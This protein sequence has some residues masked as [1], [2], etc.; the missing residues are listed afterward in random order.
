M[1][2]HTIK[3][4][5]ILFSTLIFAWVFPWLI[6][7]STND[8]SRYP[9]TYFSSVNKEFIQ[10]VKSTNNETLLKDLK[11]NEYTRDE[12]DSLLPMLSYRQL[13][14]DSRLPASLNG[15]ALNGKVI[16]ENQFY[17]RYSPRDKN[18]RVI[19]L[20]PM[21]E[22]MSGR[23]QIESPEDMFSINNKMIFIDAESNAI[24]E[25]KSELFNKALV[26]R[27]Y[28][29]PTQGVF[30][31]PSTKKLYDEGWFALDN[32]NQ[33]F[34]IKMVNGQP[35]VKDTKAGQQHQIT[36]VKTI[37]T[38]NRRMYAFV[39]TD[40][41][42]L[43]YVQD[44]DYGLVKINIDAY[45]WNTDQVSILANQFFWN[46]VVSTPTQRITYALDNTSLIEVD[47]L[48]E[49]RERTIWERIH[50]Y[51]FPFYVEV[52]SLSSTFVYPRFI[53][54]SYKAIF[55]NIVWAIILVLLTKRKKQKIRP[56]SILYVV[57]S[58]VFGFVSMLIF[59]EN[60]Q[61]TNNIIQLK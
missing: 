41:G 4:L 44:Q 52:K 21:F 53:G 14:K 16:Q 10:V 23:V 1:T 59:N 36:F 58:G 9:F 20:N 17:F 42:E 50:P 25:K 37:E 43:Y 29:F 40:K 12:Y 7:L 19:D 8:A 11:G 24:D 15:E 54:F 26:K 31:N 56:L 2:K 13:L 61:E 28:T 6:K 45:N 55:T 5:L 18:A 27:G 34:H 33:L 22:S 47:R 46:V 39:F 30:G 51:V 49:S 60:Q 48:I 32:N 57:I 3:I 38:Q 35:F